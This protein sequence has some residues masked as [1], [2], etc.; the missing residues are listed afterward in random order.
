MSTDSP[1]GKDIYLTTLYL[2][3]S[4][5]SI[6]KMTFLTTKVILDFGASN[7]YSTLDELLSLEEPLPSFDEPLSKNPSLV[8]LS[9][10]VR[11]DH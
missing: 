9:K 1:E 6:P 7:L 11:A 10:K 3:S 4:S 2:N 5:H 8:L